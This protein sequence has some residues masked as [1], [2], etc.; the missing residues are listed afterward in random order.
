M[1][2]DLIAIGAGTAGLTVADVGPRLGLKTAIIEKNKV[3]GDCTWYGCVPSKSLLKI[4][5]I[6]HS[7]RTAGDYGVHVSAPEVDMARVREYIHTAIGDIYA[8][9]TPDKIREKGTDVIEGTARFLDPH[10]LDVDGQT[11]TAG[12]VVL[13][14]GASPFV[15][16][17]TGLDSVPFHTNHTIFDNER[18]PDH[19]M[20][21]GAGPIGCEL[22]QAYRRLGA[23][24]TLVD[25]NFMGINDADATAVMQQ[26]FEREG[27]RV[28]DGLV[29]HASMQGEDIVLRTNSGHELRGDMLLVA[30]GRR[31]NV[32]GLGLDAAGVAYTPQGITVDKRLKTTAGHIYAAGDCVGP[33]YFTH[34]AGWQAFQALRNM[35]IPLKA[36]GHLAHVPHVTFTDPEVAQ[37]GLTE[38]EAREQY[39]DDI[40]VA[41]VHNDEV[42]RLVA[43]DDRSG[44]IKVIH[45]PNGTILGAT[46]VGDRARDANIEF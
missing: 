21:I 38:S 13:A 7:A 10:T 45:R 15:P 35:F 24:V 5:R 42:D 20:I 44:F 40:V 4:A 9:E 32:E 34:Y 28:V 27:I 46:I 2:Y 16:P 18:L 1:H 37:A 36:P 22:G 14:T 8:H 26:V 39:G 41:T 19:L 31:P 30:A 33:P 6:A 3:G 11:I 43:E 23:D 17:I 12:H 25:V 29:E